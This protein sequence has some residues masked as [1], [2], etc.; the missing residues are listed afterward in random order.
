[1]P[2]NFA[3]IGTGKIAR[4]SLA[5]ALNEINE[6]SFWSVLSRSQKRAESFASQYGALSS[7][8]AYSSY[9]DLLTDT[10][11]DAVIITTPDKLHAEYGIEA[12]QAGKHVL[13]EKPMVTDAEDGKRL[14]S[15]CRENQVKLGVAY[16]LRWH[17]GHRKLAF[18]VHNGELGKLHHMRVQWTSKAEDDS[19]WRANNR[20]GRWWSLAAVGTHCLDLI[21]WMMVPSCGE[22][23]EVKGLIANNFWNSPNDET[24]IISMKFESGATAEITSSVL[25][26]STPAVEIY[27][28]KGKAICKDTL[29]PHGKGEIY[30]NEKDLKYNPM[31]PYPGEIADFVKAIQNGRRPE[32]DGKEGLKNIQIL[33]KATPRSDAHPN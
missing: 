14:I 15:I 22:V 31:N 3:I 6:A 13:M 29:G 32:V 5:P 4:R 7:N 28:R 8:P 10:N 25:F 33:L 17:S 16:H 18:K 21:R 1:M 11:L 23:I 2:I 12:A 24:A 26:D 20:L 9:S 19:N 30:F 27:G